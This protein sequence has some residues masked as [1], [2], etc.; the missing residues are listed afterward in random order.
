MK[1]LFF[2]L[3]AILAVAIVPASVAATPEDPQNSNTVKVTESNYQGFIATDKL[4]VLDFWAPW[5][6]PCRAIA[7]ILEELAAEYQGKI[8]VGKCNVDENGTLTNNF[9]VRGIP[10][11]FFIKNGKVVDEQ[12]GYCAKDFMKEKIDKLLK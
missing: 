1:K 9:G 7:P 8:V 10:A 5:C 11:I 3:A 2:V 6:G 4:V 12:I